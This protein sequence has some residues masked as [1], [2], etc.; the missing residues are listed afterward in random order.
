MRLVP[1]SACELLSDDG[2]SACP[3]CGAPRA[4]GPS[5]RSRAAIALGLAAFA[6]SAVAFTPGCAYGGPPDYTP[7]QSSAT[8]SATSD[9]ASPPASASAASS[10]APTTSK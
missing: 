1:C 4:P 2:L 10:A 3:H 5:R 8:A 6:G 9:Q 7:P